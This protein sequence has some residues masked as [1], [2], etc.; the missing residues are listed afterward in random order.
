MGRFN[1]NDEKFEQF[2]KNMEKK[3]KDIGSTVTDD[4][5]PEAKESLRGNI[6]VTI[7]VTFL[8]GLVTGVVLSLFRKK[9]GKRR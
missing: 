8:I 2:F 9:S 4:V 3:I 1:G 7:V 6:I 5:I